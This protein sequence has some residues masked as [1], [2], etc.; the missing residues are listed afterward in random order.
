MRSIFFY[1]LALL[2]LFLEIFLITGIPV[3]KVTFPLENTEAVFFTLSQNISGSRDFAISLFFKVL[4]N[5]SLYFLLVVLSP[6]LISKLFNLLNHQ[7]LF[8]IHPK[9]SFFR[10]ITITNVVALAILIHTIYTQLP[11]IDYYFAW[12]DSISVPEHSEIYQK[13]YVSPDTAHIQFKEKKNLILIFLESMEYNFQDSAHGGNL[14]E[15]LIPEITNY[16]QTEQSFVPGGSPAWGMGWTMAD[17]VAKTCGIPLALPSSITGSFT[18]PTYFLPGVTCLSDIL[19]NEGYNFMVS[20]GANLKFSSMDVFLKSHLST[21]AFGLLEYLKDPR[22]NDITTSKWGVRDSLHYELVKEHIERLSAQEKPWAMWLF[23]VD[24]HTPYGYLDPTCASDTTIS[25]KEQLP[26]VI[27]CTSR[28]LDNFIKWAKKQSWF[29]NTTI[30]VMGDHA[31]MADPEIV[32]FKDPVA[33]H[34]WLDF[35]I[36]SAKKA[37]HYQRDFTSLD[38]FPTILESIGAEIPNGALGLGRSLFSSNPTLLEKYGTDSLNNA[39]KKRSIEYNYFLFNEK[40]K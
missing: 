17:A 13:E 23:T 3:I 15:N 25:E 29:S 20:K 10:F 36:N 37:E 12:K 38:F 31:I 28:Q 35:F 26:F 9:K 22:V 8:R 16:I 19:T 7:R 39:L 14:S 1:T 11:I 2:S 6:G 21:Q 33:M 27:K 18:T 5:A 34:Y 30:A 4:K 40:K 32:G 24:T